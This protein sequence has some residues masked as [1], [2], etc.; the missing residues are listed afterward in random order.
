[1][2]VYNDRINMSFII[3][4]PHY[5]NFAIFQFE[6]FAEKPNPKTYQ[7]Y[8]SPDITFFSI[9]FHKIATDLN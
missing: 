5:S 7:S 1:M 3:S 6:K 2:G 9:N 8:I 4:I